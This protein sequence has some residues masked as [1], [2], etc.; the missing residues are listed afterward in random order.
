MLMNPSL[1]FDTTNYTC[2][3]FYIQFY[4]EGNS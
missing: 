2:R 4:D 1:E 3:Y